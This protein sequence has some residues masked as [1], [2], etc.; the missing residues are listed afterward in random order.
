MPGS[1][2]FDGVAQA[3]FTADGHELRLP[4]FYY[5]GRAVSAVFPARLRALR[6]LL[7][8]RRFVPARLAPG[9]GLLA[10]T[11]FEYTDTDVGVYNELAIS[12]VLHDPPYL[13][14]LP[15]L[16][17]ARGLRRNALH[18]FV[19]H[20]PV[21][22]EIALVSGR[23]FWNYP[24]FVTDIEFSDEP[25]ALV[26]TLGGADAPILSLS[27]RTIPTPREADLQ[28]FCHL[29]MDRQPQSAEFKLHATQFGQTARPGAATVKLAEGHP[30]ARELAGALLSRRALQVQHLGQ[31]EGILYGPEHLCLPQLAR[32]QAERTGDELVG[33]RGDAA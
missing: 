25:G 15:G 9:V 6:D 22:T 21:T 1:S 16:S 20:L 11:A 24:K 4:I 19:H 13:P 14:N 8:D 5:D 29:W 30:I 10:I 31:F 2:F 17:T 28:I 18:A 3:E 23:K 7:P 32:L 26:C 27:A 33:A 12:V